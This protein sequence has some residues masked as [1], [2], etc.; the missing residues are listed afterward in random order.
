MNAPLKSCTV[1]RN[2][3]FDAAGAVRLSVLIPFY[4]DNPAPLL[5]RLA[6]SPPQGAEI[7]LYD[8]GSADAV[9]TGAVIEAVQEAPLPA[10][11]ISAQHNCGRACARNALTRAARGAWVLLL[12]ADMMPPDAAFLQRWRACVDKLA[13]A[14]AFGGFAV[15]PGHSVA[16]EQRLHQAF[17][18]HSDCLPAAVRMQNPASHVCTSNL[19]VRKD[20]L[21][22]VP[23]DDGFDGWGWE[24]VE[25]AARAG[26][27]YPIIHID[28]P[29]LHLGLENPGTLLRRFRDSAANYARFVHRHPALARSLPSWKAARMAAK[30]PGFSRLRPLFAAIAR[31]KAGLWPLRARILALKL[32]RSSWYAKALS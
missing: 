19:L 3:A 28:N 7:I 31:N 22:A 4:R 6:A 11:L 15:P 27:H 1:V 13:P 26:Q 18:Q 17:S 8:D 16:P 14:I 30:I 9:L 23:F 29:A 25:W 5:K 20:V 10:M 12:D 32:W 21:Q 24:D 2:A